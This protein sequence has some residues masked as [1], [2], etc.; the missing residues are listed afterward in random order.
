MLRLNKE[1]NTY[2]L[3]NFGVVQ[4]CREGKPTN[5]GS[6]QR[7]DVSSACSFPK[8]YSLYTA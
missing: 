7:L 1:G 2:S 6:D 8:D 4:K 5:L 3:T